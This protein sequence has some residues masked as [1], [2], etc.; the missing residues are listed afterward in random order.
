V[1]L[2]EIADAELLASG[3]KNL[4]LL[5]LGFSDFDFAECFLALAKVF[6][7]VRQKTLSKEPFADTRFPVYPKCLPS[8]FLTLPIFFLLF[9][10]FNFYFAECFL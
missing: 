7:N 3:L 5:F 2:I 6:A 8:A 4:F 1:N 9:L 10:F